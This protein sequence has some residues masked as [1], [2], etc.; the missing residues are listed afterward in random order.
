MADSMDLVQ[1]RVEENLHRHIQNA[2]ARQP[3][4]MTRSGLNFCC[5]RAIFALLISWSCSISR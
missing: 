2:R 5:S 4:R 3:A 1:Q